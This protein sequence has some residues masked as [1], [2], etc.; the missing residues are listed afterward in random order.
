MNVHVDN[1]L[2]CIWQSARHRIM[3]HIIL[4]RGCNL[5]YVHTTPLKNKVKILQV[6]LFTEFS[7][8]QSSVFFLRHW[9]CGL[10]F[11]ERFTHGHSWRHVDYGPQCSSEFGLR[12]ERCTVLLLKYLQGWED[13]ETIGIIEP[14]K[15]KRKN[16]LKTTS[17]IRKSTKMSIGSWRMAGRIQQAQTHTQH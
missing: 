11:E 3:K 8:L 4:F 17:F 9:R 6:L 10:F 13:S 1:F 7:M 16:F 12:L 14:P 2:S 15:K 5:V